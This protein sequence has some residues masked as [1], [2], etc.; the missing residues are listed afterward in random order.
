VGEE[1]SGEQVSAMTLP[2][3]SGNNREKDIHV[4]NFNI[5]FGGK[6]LLENA[7][8]RFV[9]GRR[10]GLVGKNGIGKTTLLRHMASFDIEGFPRHHRV[11]HV[12]Q[13]VQAS[14][15]TVLEVSECQMK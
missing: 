13:E 11:L 8:L 15:A 12:K 10:Y 1:D 3:Y 9:F 2:D 4:Q 5:T 14:A 7:D 6:L